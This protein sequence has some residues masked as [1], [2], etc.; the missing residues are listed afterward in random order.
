MSDLFKT[1]FV[2][3]GDPLPPDFDGDLQDFQDALIERLSIQSPEGT[4]F[5]VSGDTEPATN[6]GPWLKNGDRWYVFSATE[7]GYVPINIDDSVTRVFVVSQTDPGTP[8]ADDPVIWL[9]T[10][11]T[12]AIT[13]YFWDG[14]AWRP[15]GNPPPSGTTAQRPVSPVEL[16][17][18]FDTDINCLIHFE[19]GQWRTV[20]GT[21][22]DIKFVTTATLTAAVTANPG[23]E[24]VG[25]NDITCR[26]KVF[27]VATKDPGLSPSTSFP[28]DSGISARAQADA[29]GQEEVI[30]N[31]TQIEQ[32]SHVVGSATLLNSDN[33]AFFQRV[34]DGQGPG[35]ADPD[36]I[37]VPGPKPPNHFEVRGDGSINGT[38][39]GVMPD[40]P[41]G[42]MF[43]TSRQF[44]LAAVPDYTGAALPHTNM[45]PTKFVWALVKL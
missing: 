44:S 33:N 13:W 25:Q 8:G 34:D 39:N 26:G 45:Q 18:F 27:G 42:T 2:I 41:N 22:G 35:A 43:I 14:S 3:V 30:L 6:V 40:P 29:V 31:S 21:P 32:H 24:Y 23:W 12:R 1:N 16:E 11:G 20:A 7:G 9:R 38:K 17:Q 37:E 28:T 5:F 10:V 4:N 15:G 19:R 36:K